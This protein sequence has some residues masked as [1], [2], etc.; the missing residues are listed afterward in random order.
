LPA[1]IHPEQIHANISK[2]GNSTENS[3]RISRTVVAK[4]RSK[5]G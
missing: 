1:T 5:P 2:T 3:N 4:G